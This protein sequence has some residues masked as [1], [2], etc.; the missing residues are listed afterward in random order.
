MKRTPIKSVS[1]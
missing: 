1:S